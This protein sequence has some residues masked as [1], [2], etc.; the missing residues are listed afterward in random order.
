MSR[1][2][3]RQ[4]IEVRRANPGIAVKTQVA[5][6]LVVGHD[7]QDVGTRGYFSGGHIRQT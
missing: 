4:A 3:P 7:E 6:A 2:L 5:I 1:A